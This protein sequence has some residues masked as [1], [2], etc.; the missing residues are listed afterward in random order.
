MFSILGAIISW[1]FLDFAFAQLIFVGIFIG[2]LGQLG[3][4]SESLF[5]RD[6]QI[7]DSGN[8]F[9]GMGGALDII[10]SLLFTAPVF[11]IYV[12][13]KIPHLSIL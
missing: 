8:L 1:R 13:V 7:K 9:P 3:D 4:L 10:D 11:Y 5:K 12:V 6:C 2:L